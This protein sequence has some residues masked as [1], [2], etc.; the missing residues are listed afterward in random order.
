MSDMKVDQILTQ[1]RSLRDQ[2][3]ISRP[4]DHAN[5]FDVTNVGGTAKVD[6]GSVLKQSIDAV[7][8]TQKSASTLLTAFERG[9]PDVSLTEVMVS[10][11]KSSIGFKAMVEVRNKFVDAYQEVMRM[12]M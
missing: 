9:D 11:Q 6:F 1:I 8:D 7:S 4:A 3:A 2:T 10:T 5:S 12:S